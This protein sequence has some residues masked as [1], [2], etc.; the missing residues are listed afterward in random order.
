MV[1][2]YFKDNLVDSVGLPYYEYIKFSATNIMPIPA[3]SNY[4]LS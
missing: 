4:D 1:A 2:N 3:S